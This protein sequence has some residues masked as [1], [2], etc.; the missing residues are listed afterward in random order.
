MSDPLRQEL[1]DIFVGRATRRYG[2]SEINQLQHALQAAALAEA[3][4]RAARHRARLRCCTM[5]AT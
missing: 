2:L 3:D 5:S 1:L 4:E